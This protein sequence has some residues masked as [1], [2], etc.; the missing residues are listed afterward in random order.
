MK[1]I[2]KHLVHL[3]AAQRSALQTFVSS[4]QKKAREI[5]RARILLLADAGHT[6]A[7]IITALGCCRPVVWAMR[8]RYAQ[9]DFDTIIDVLHEAPRQ[10]RPVRIDSRVESQITMI[11]CSDPPPGAARWTLHLIADQLVKLEMVDSISHER[12]RQALKK[13]A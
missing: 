10:G 9:G 6:D 12:V 5:T 11:A 4:G 8:K 2:T 3:T 1:R 7:E 13:T